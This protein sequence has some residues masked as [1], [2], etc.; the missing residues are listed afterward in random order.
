VLAQFGGLNVLT[1]PIFAERASPFGFVGPRR[2]HPPGVAQAELP[3]IDLVLVSHNHYDHLD[4]H[5]V[6]LLAA[7]PGGSPLFIVP[8]G[9]A[10]GWRGA[11]CA[12]R[13]SSTGGSSTA[14]ARST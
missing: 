9:C 3:P 4:E 7:Q 5:A 11:A 14:S 8:L 6:R 13:S 1:D 10:T 2:H 12:T